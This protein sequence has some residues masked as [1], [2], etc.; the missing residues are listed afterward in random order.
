MSTSTRRSDDR[1]QADGDRRLS[2]AL[3][4]E[5]AGVGHAIHIEYDLCDLPVV[6]CFLSMIG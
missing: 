2:M 4:G 1:R 3:G 5:I 6:I